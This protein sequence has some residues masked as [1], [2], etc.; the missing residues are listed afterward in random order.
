M[1]ILNFEKWPLGKV[2]KAHYHTSFLLEWLRIF[3]GLRSKSTSAKLRE[4]T[5]LNERYMMMGFQCVHLIVRNC[6]R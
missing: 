5:F 4:I 1:A 6:Y 2:T 3:Y